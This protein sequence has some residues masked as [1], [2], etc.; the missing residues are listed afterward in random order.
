[1]RYGDTIVFAAATVAKTTRPGIDF[2][3]AHGGL[4]GAPVRCGEDPGSFPRREGRPSRRASFTARLTDR[5]FARSSQRDSRTTVQIVAS[6]WSAD[7]ENDYDV[8]GRQRRVR[9]AHDLGT[10]PSKGRSDAFASARSVASSRS[11]DHPAD[12]RERSRPPRGRDARL[13]HDDRGRRASGDRGLPRRRSRARP[14]RHQGA[15]RGAGGARARRRQAEAP[16]RP[17]SRQHGQ[18]RA[19]RRVPQGAHSRQAPQSG[20]GTARDGA[21]S[22]QGGSGRA[23]RQRGQPCSRRREVA[24]TTRRSSRKNFAARSP[25]RTCGQMAATGRRFRPLSIEVGVLPRTHGSGLFTRGQTQVLSV[26]TLGPTG[27]EQIIDTLSR[28]TPSATCITTTS[29]R[30]RSVRCG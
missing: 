3:P 24:A 28:W 19:C 4:R 8:P 1:M 5:P 2:F 18:A 23:V 17:V 27:D 10:R 13:D 20:Q 14:G 16:D 26:T 25:K 6:A 11:T 21:R 30:T 9:R 22:P 15:V 12:G 7:Q 29:R